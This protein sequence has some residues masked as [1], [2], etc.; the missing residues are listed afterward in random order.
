MVE[1]IAKRKIFRK[2]VAEVKDLGDEKKRKNTVFSSEKQ[3]W[4][5]QGKSKEYLRKQRKCVITTL[6]PLD[7]WNEMKKMFNDIV[8]MVS[9]RKKYTNKNSWLTFF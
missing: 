3:A 7:D 6:K 4:A 2:K 8:F 9:G 5:S 1:V